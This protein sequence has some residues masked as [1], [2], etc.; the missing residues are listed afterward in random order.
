MIGCGLDLSD[1]GWRPFLGCC[2]HGNKYLGF[3]KCGEC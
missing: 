2:E 3:I 1:L